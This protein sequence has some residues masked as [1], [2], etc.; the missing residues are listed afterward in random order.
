[1]KNLMFA[2]VFVLAFV[3]GTNAQNR[4][5]SIQNRVDRLKERLNLTDAQTAKID[6][7]LTAA[8]D[9]ARAIPDSI[10]D[11]R[12]AMRQI[13]T[14]ANADV[15]KILTDDQKAEYKKMMEERRGRMRRR[16]YNGN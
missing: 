4:R 8:M 6:S 9:S 7:I 14:N 3:L 13:M 12:Q 11:R 10:Q 15:E 1:M 5:F 16:P 2:A